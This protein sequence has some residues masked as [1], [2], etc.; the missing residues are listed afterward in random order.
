[1]LPWKKYMLIIFRLNISKMNKLSKY[2]KLEG[3]T[4]MS[5]T[6][7]PIGFEYRMLHWKLKKTP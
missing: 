7:N 2:T 1:M 6:L 5:A 4:L 3:N